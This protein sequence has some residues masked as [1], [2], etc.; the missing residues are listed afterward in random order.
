MRKC[1]YLG[2]ESNTLFKLNHSYYYTKRRRKLRNENVYSCSYT[3]YELNSIRVKYAECGGAWFEENFID[4]L[5]E[6]K[7]KLQKINGK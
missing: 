6:R 4:I 2:I 7:L 1:K 5:D 3:I